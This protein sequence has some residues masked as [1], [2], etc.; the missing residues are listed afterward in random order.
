MQGTRIRAFVLSFVSVALTMSV[1]CSSLKINVSVYDGPMVDAPEARLAWG[2]G[3][4]RAIKAIAEDTSARGQRPASKTDRMPRYAEK[5]A[6]LLD[7]LA[8]FY[9]D[10]QIDDLFNAFVVDGERPSRRKLSR[11]LLAFAADAQAIAQRIGLP[12]LVR[13]QMWE[14]LIP[15][16]RNAEYVAA[17]VAIDES[18]RILQGL[19]DSSLNEDLK[20]SLSGDGNN[21]VYLARIR[22]VMASQAPG[23]LLTAIKNN[24][25][26]YGSAVKRYIE[27]IY[28]ERY[29]KPFNPLKVGAIGGDLTTLM[30]KDE[31]GNWQLKSV[32]TDPKK[33]IEAGTS[34]IKAVLVLLDPTSAPSTSETPTDGS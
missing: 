21:A 15:N 32:T 19:A 4:A 3:L 24:P 30:V 9:N 31:I 17:L 20:S 1:G 33:A 6:F 16:P 8:G 22:H 10:L 5:D 11:A 34:V 26:W 28:D 13:S 14:L 12:E 29:W 18:G 25:A 27:R 7:D 2:V 23:T